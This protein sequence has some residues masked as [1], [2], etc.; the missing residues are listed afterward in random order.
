[1]NNLFT[2]KRQYGAYV[3][4]RTYQ[5]PPPPCRW[6]PDVSAVPSVT[7]HHGPARL[8]PPQALPEPHGAPHAAGL[9]GP[10]GWLAGD[11]SEAA[12]RPPCALRAAASVPRAR[13]PCWVKR[14]RLLLQRAHACSDLRPLQWPDLLPWQPPGQPSMAA[15]RWPC[16]GLHACGAWRTGS[17]VSG[18]VRPRGL[19]SARALRAMSVRVSRW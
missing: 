3:Q 4:V 15:L 19:C 12:T 9:T 18:E 2:A 11:T 17:R 14:R 16:G 5:W 7:R 6:E 8:C 10:P 13:L 1:M